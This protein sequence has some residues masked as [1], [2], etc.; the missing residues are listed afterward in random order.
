M[1][2]LPDIGV[3]VLAI[4]GQAPDPMGWN[5]PRSDVLSH[6]PPG[7]R[8]EVLDD[9]GHFAHIERPG[10]V[11]DRILEFLGPVGRAA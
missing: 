5:T 4:L 2:R 6:L 3:P 7:G 9:V 11:A 1:M 10:E 8:L